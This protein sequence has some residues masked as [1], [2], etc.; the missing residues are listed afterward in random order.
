MEFAGTEFAKVVLVLLGCFISTVVPIPLNCNLYTSGWGNSEGLYYTCKVTDLRTES[1]NITVDNVIGNHLEGK[2]DDD[3][4]HFVVDNSPNMRYLPHGVGDFFRNLEEVYI[5]NTS[6]EAIT[7]SDLKQF[8]VLEQLT[9]TQTQLKSLE[10]G[11]FQYSTKLKVLDLSRNRI[12]SIAPDVLRPLTDLA[13]VSLKNNVCIDI[14]MYLK[15][16]VKRVVQEI[17]KRCQNGVA[18]SATAEV[19]NSSN[20]AIIFP[21]VD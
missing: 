16:G 9:L 5:T 7:Q 14:D 19:N 17:I 21:E 4:K 18:S 12:N 13:Y 3:V 6:L 10:S 15:N 2:T 11:L 1:P 8:P 20:P